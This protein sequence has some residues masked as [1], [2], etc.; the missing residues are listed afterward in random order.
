MNLK[1]FL[2]FKADVNVKTS[3]ILNEKKYLKKE[4]VLNYSIF[5]TC[6]FTDQ[7]CVYLNASFVLLLSCFII[8]QTPW[9]LFPSHIPF[10]LRWKIL[11]GSHEG[12]RYDVD[13]LN[14]PDEGSQGRGSFWKNACIHR[15]FNHTVPDSNVN[16][17]VPYLIVLH[18]I[19]LIRATI[20]IKLHHIHIHFIITIGINKNSV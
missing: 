10:K 20:M 2:L 17:D 7:H 11:Q 16:L 1:T 3:F 6:F 15:F 4:Y 12:I 9:L 8:F 14:S 13:F 19:F 5:L 18:C